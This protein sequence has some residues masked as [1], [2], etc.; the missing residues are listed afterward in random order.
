MIE[1]RTCVPV[2]ERARRAR[3]QHLVDLRQ[4]GLSCAETLQQ[5]SAVLEAVEQTYTLQRGVLQRI[6]AMPVLFW[7][8]DELER[9]V[10]LAECLER[11][12]QQE[13]QLGDPVNTSRVS[14]K[15]L[16]GFCVVDQSLNIVMSPLYSKE[17]VLVDREGVLILSRDLPFVKDH[18]ECL[19]TFANQ[20][21]VL[22]DHGVLTAFPSADVGNLLAKYRRAKMQDWTE[23]MT[24]TDLGVVLYSHNHLKEPVWL[25]FRTLDVIGAPV[26]LKGQPL[27]NLCHFHV[28]DSDFVLATYKSYAADSPRISGLR[29]VHQKT[30]QVNEILSS[31]FHVRGAISKHGLVFAWSDEK[32]Y[33]I[34]PKADWLVEHTVTTNTD[35]VKLSGIRCCAF[36]REKLY[37]QGSHGLCVVDWTF[38]E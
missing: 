8:Q 11:K 18:I 9:Q 22:H 38:P 25:D 15:A 2:V 6:H 28:L 1:T 10:P 7:N 17:L 33:V 29:A 20:L 30:G 14:N 32:V 3:R 27:K 4:Q 24:V 5:R 19:A 16:H 13:V 21:Y 36:L 26:F 37:A 23:K 35:G 34:N 12:V 31:G